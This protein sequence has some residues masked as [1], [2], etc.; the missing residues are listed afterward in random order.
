SAY[1]GYAAYKMV[2]NQVKKAMDQQK[3]VNLE[4]RILKLIIRKKQILIENS[5]NYLNN[6]LKE[7][8]KNVSL[9]TEEIKAPAENNLS[10]NT[11]IENWLKR[12]SYILK[13]QIDSLQNDEIYIF[14]INELKNIMSSLKNSLAK[15]FPINEKENKNLHIPSLTASM[16]QKMSFIEI[17]TNPNI[18]SPKSPIK[19]TSWL[20]TNIIP[21]L[22]GLIPTILG[23][24]GSIFVY[25]DGIPKT[26]EHLGFHQL[27][28]YISNPTVKIMELA[29][30]LII[31]IYFGVSYVHSNRKAFKRSQQLQITQKLVTNEESTDIEVNTKLNLIKK[32]KTQIRKVKYIF[33]ILKKI[34]TYLKKN[35]EKI[36]EYEEAYLKVKQQLEEI[37]QKTKANLHLA[38]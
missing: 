27:D 6:S 26:L 5:I 14:Y 16:N 12:L 19:K 31:T 7:L 25:V 3:L 18:A 13:K 22:I 38:G 23:G 21:L 33:K 28:S 2:A 30:A 37:E 35:Q 24:F 10:T 34:K 4:L 32:L 17:L 15:N 20:K 11:E 36:A 29:V 9:T 1:F 8:Q